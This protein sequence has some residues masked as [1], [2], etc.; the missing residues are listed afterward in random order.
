MRELRGFFSLNVIGMN[1]FRKLC[2]FYAARA[3]LLCS[4]NDEQER[5]VHDELQQRAYFSNVLW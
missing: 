2:S 4:L 5:E 1:I 3:R